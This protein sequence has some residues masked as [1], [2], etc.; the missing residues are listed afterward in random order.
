MQI[1]RFA[2]CQEWEKRSYSNFWFLL[3][4]LD[5]AQNADGVKSVHDVTMM[6]N[7]DAVSIQS[8]STTTMKETQQSKEFA[9]CKR[10]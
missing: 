10:A 9:V 8:C 5:N 1:M 4:V 6:A 3:N 7:G 2:V